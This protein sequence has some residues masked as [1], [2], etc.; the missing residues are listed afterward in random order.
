[1]DSKFVMMIGA[2]RA[3]AIL[4]TLMFVLYDVYVGM[5]LVVCLRMFLKKIQKQLSN[6]KF[7]ILK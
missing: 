3:R 1:M 4:S 6:A 7:W 5:M 2:H